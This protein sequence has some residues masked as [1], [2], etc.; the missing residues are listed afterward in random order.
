MADKRTA[1]YVF[2]TGK[3]GRVR[4]GLTPAAG[5]EF[6]EKMWTPG[7]LGGGPRFHGTRRRTRLEAA[8]KNK[9]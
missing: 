1:E 9:G 6:G 2:G 5:C 3:L 7:Q 4:S 8:L